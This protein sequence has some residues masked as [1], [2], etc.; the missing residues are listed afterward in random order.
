MGLTMVALEGDLYGWA[1]KGLLGLFWVL[2]MGSSWVNKGRN[3]VFLEPSYIHTV[4]IRRLIT[5][6]I[7]GPSVVFSPDKS[8]S[9]K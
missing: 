7:L 5:R 2:S 8:R 9:S 3:K 6:E 4:W 1:V